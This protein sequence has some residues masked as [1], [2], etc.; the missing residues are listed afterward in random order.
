MRPFLVGPRAGDNDCFAKRVWSQAWAAMRLRLLCVDGEFG[1]AQPV[2]DRKNG[3]MSS[4]VSTLLSAIER[5][6]SHVMDELLPL[7]YDQLRELAR[8][9]LAQETAGQTLQATALVH[10]AYIRLVDAPVAQEWRSRK[11]FFAAG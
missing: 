1:I 4:D 5:G 7:V 8:A 11:Y 9:K 2:G 3:N 6:N 10:E